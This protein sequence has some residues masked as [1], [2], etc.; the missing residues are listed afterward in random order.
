MIYDPCE[1]CDPM[2]P[3]QSSTD[4]KSYRTEVISCQNCKF[5]KVKQK[6]KELKK[7]IQQHT[8]KCINSNKIIGDCVERAAISRMKAGEDPYQVLKDYKIKIKK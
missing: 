6:I 3:K 5:G 4:T 8:V 2:P 1:E 7:Y